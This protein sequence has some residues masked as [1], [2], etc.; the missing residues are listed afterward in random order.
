MNTA[1]PLQEVEIVPNEGAVA[2]RLP[3]SSSRFFGAFISPRCAVNQMAAVVVSSSAARF[4]SALTFRPE[5]QVVGSSEWFCFD[6]L[7]VRG[8]RNVPAFGIAPRSSASPPNNS[9]EP[10]PVTKAAFLRVSC[11]AAQLNR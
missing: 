6:A 2:P 10:T 1:A 4:R 11:G 5:R 3:E 8:V 9:L 7:P